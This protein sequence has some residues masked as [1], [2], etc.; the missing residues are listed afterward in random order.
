M[1]GILLF[2]IGFLLCLS[3]FYGLIRRI[4]HINSLLQQISIHSAHIVGLQ[5]SLFIDEEAGRERA[6]AVERCHLAVFIKDHREGLAAL[7]NLFLAGIHIRP[8]MHHQEGHFSLQFLVFGVEFRHFHLTGAAPMG[9]EI[10]NNRFACI[11]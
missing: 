6:D 8:H 4:N 9:P 3:L 2:I 11:V 1:W 10:Q 7:C 5:I